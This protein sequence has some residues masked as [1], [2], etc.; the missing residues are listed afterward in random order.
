MG[1][2]ANTYLR[3]DV[4]NITKQQVINQFNTY[5]YTSSFGEVGIFKEVKFFASDGVVKFNYQTIIN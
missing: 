5:G 1:I 3:L 4:P 2:I